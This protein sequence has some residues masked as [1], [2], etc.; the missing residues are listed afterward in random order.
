MLQASR[1]YRMGRGQN[2]SCP[3]WTMS[4][5]VVQSYFGNAVSLEHLEENL[6]G[7]IISNVSKCIIRRDLKLM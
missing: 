3:K 4:G 1:V 6:I 2:G 7:L 5:Q